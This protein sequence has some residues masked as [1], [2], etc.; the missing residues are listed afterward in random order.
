MPADTD[1]V[2]TPRSLAD[3]DAVVAALLLA[4]AGLVHLAVA[5]AHFAEW[6][7][8]GVL[9]GVAAAAQIVLAVLVVRVP[10]TWVLA[11]T[12]LVDA[13]LIAVWAWSRTSGLPVGPG[14]GTPE[15]AGWLDAL[16]VLAEVL[17]I[18]LILPRRRAGAGPVVAGT[19][20]LGAGLSVA[21]I[22]AF[23]GGAGHA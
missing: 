8:F 4:A 3:A 17:V 13:A 11:A 1:G 23:A 5:P 20:T 18:A 15:A 12:L 2:R 14:A 9:F 21:L 7:L 22:L 6:W 10:T 16:T 19:R